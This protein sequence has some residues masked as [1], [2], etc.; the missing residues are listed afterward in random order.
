MGRF[1]LVLSRKINT[2][3]RLARMVFQRTSASETEGWGRR[4][5]ENKPLIIDKDRWSA[6]YFPL[7][8]IWR[9]P[10]LLVY[11]TYVDL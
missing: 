4:W 3:K 1:A 11:A 8:D 5:M 6:G 7:N 2:K 9:D 10:S